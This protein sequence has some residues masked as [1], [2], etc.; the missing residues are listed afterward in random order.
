VTAAHC[1][2]S[3]RQRLID[4]P[5]PFQQRREERTGAQLRDPS[6]QITDRRGQDR[7]AVP[8]ACTLRSTLNADLARAGRPRA[9]AGRG[10]NRDC[11]GPDWYRDRRAPS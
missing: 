4:P 3:T 10:E 9:A 7:G 8:I 1:A 11:L 6:V 2:S 5:P